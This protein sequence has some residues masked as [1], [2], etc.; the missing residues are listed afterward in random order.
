MYVVCLFSRS[1]PKIERRYG[2]MVS[3]MP[4]TEGREGIQYHMHIHQT[5]MVVVG[6]KISWCNT[7]DHAW[8]NLKVEMHEVCWKESNTKQQLHS[9]VSKVNPR[10]WIH[11][12]KNHH[13]IPTSLLDHTIIDQAEVV[14]TAQTNTV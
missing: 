10:G 9:I 5:S 7:T 8:K 6:Q 3:C 1:L 13:C 4:N 2:G 12:T 14:K 11:A